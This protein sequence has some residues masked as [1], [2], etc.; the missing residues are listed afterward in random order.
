MK[1]WRQPSLARGEHRQAEK[2]Y[3]YIAKGR[4]KLARN[5]NNFLFVNLSR[6]TYGGKPESARRVR[7]D[8]VAR[9]PKPFASEFAKGILKRR[10]ESLKQ[11]L[12]QRQAGVNARL[13]ISL[14]KRIPAQ[15]PHSF[16]DAGA[17]YTFDFFPEKQ[18]VQ[19]YANADIHEQSVIGAVGHLSIAIDGKGRNA[20]ITQIQGNTSR[21]RGVV[22]SKTRGKYLK[23]QEALIEAAKLFCG[24]RG[25]NLW[26]FTPAVYGQEAK[27]QDPNA[28]ARIKLALQEVPGKYEKILEKHAPPQEPELDPVFHEFPALLIHRAQ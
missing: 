3:D 6:A 11:T 27:L 12:A 8:S 9:A 14:S 26:M 17:H 25:L 7:R 23:W 1:L 28:S 22:S 10:A 15:L 5:L 21:E 13:V 2:I 4:G 19:N 18:H 24:E 20:V 16:H